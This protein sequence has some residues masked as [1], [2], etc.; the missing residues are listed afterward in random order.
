MCITTEHELAAA[1][2][3]G[4]KLTTEERRIRFGGAPHPRAR[5]DAYEAEIL[6][7]FDAGEPMTRA[8]KREA[9]RIKRGRP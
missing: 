4:R 9:R 3:A 1:V 5:Q 8:D 7:R 2:R 6:R